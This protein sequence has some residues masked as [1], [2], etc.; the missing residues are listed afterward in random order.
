M[1]GKCN[2][3]CRRASCPPGRRWRRP[4]AGGSVLKDYQAQIR[5]ILTV[6]RDAVLQSDE[7]QD[8]ERERSVRLGRAATEQP[9]QSPAAS[10]GQERK[11]HR[12]GQERGKQQERAGQDSTTDRGSK[13]NQEERPRAP[14]IRS[15]AGERHATQQ[16]ADPRHEPTGSGRLR[17]E[18][19]GAPTAG[20]D[21]VGRLSART[22]SG[23][24]SPPAGRAQAHQGGFAGRIA[25]GRQDHACNAPALRS[26]AVR[27]RRARAS[28]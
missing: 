21:P 18:P 22:C 7:L 9:S 1:T 28:S 14:A 6:A 15:E 27:S 26:A 19:V 20:V 11:P 16:I 24:G 5:G 17:T 2:P 23:C 4:G 8:R 12:G 25:A 3:G 13:G 10:P